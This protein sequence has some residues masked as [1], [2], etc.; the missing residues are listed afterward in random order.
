MPKNYTP[1][2]LP[3]IINYNEL[4]SDIV[5]AHDAISE[6]KGL[7]TTLN[8]P[9]LLAR[10]LLTKEAI[11]SSKIE[12]TQVDIQDVLEYEIKNTQNQNTE[13]EKDNREV[14]N[15]RKAMYFA[16]SEIEKRPINSKLIKDIHAI[17]LD[18]V[19]G[20]DKDKGKFR[21]KQVFIGKSG[22]NIEKATYIP[23]SAEEIEKLMKNLEEYMNSFF[24][25]DAIVQIAVIHHQFES[26]HPF[27]DGNG[28]IGRLLI[29]LF[30]Y[31]RKFLPYPL[32]YISE[33][34]EENRREYYTYLQN[35]EETGEWEEWV[36]FFL[37]SI[38]VQSYK[39]Q[40]TVKSMMKLYEESKNKISQISSGY[41]IKLLDIIF[42]YPIISFVKIKEL[43]N[44]NSNQT[45]YNLINKFVEIGILSENNKQKRNK[46]FIFQELINILK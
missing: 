9:D 23:P 42:D 13:E 26:I 43:L 7:L 30:L 6:L 3:P 41:A 11:L 37:H 39:T 8:N 45:I 15:Y 5:E 40:K 27:L 33:Y 1:R 14:M 21:D 25:K 10:S 29:S 2:E 18:S 19:R 38:T 4:I 17:L 16:I 12:G 28:R 34:L 24:E 31:Q 46:T 32:I 36:R 22:T 20:E 35:V 44:A